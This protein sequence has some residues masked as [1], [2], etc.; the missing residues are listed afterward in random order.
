M[1]DSS[2]SGIAKLVLQE[3]VNDVKAAYSAK[4]KDD[5]DISASFMDF[6]SQSSFSS[7]KSQAADKSVEGI[8]AGAV[9]EGTPMY[10]SYAKKQDSISVKE[11]VTAKTVQETGQKELEEFAEDVYQTLEEEYQ[12]SKEDIDA[13]L[14]ILG[15]TV[16]DL[17]N[18]RNLMAFVTALTGEDVGTLFLSENFQNV[19]QEISLLTE[20]LAADLGITKE[21]LAALCEEMKENA[22]DTDF[23]DTMA[24]VTD[25]EAAAEPQ[26]KDVQAADKQAQVV[27][28]VRDEGEEVNSREV[29]IQE[30]T[31]EKTE[32]K[33]SVQVVSSQSEEGETEGGQENSKQSSF[34]EHGKS[35]SMEH[36]TS[37]V[38][39]AGQQ[40]SRLESFVIPENG[41]VPSYTSQVNVADIMEQIANHVRLHIT[42]ETT[43]MEMQLNPEHLGKIYLNISERDGVI[44]AQIAAQ[45]ETVKEALE[46]QMATLR[47]NLNQQGIKVD[48]IE[49]TVATHEFEQNLEGQAKQEQQNGQQMEENQKK[50]RRSLNLNDLDSLS[51]LMS[52]EEELVAKIM[53]DNG[54]QVDITV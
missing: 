38:H 24:Q 33:Q 4:D 32:E 21:Q 2:I 19:M 7:S 53:R 49:V 13:V 34:F 30:E 36:D 46:T 26:A 10:D 37:N 8:K 1:A 41:V 51:G 31:P 15:L 52:E 54:N 17:M 44:R 40:N 45:N 50:S 42:P 5:V 18:P 14:E 3:R 23:A 16:T 9:S 27:T 20:E 29:V 35:G 11:D 12:V 25:D 6:M 22:P 39:I 28:V 43:S 47:Q 48:A